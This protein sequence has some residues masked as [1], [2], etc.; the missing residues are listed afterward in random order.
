MFEITCKNRIPGGEDVVFDAEEIE[1]KNGN[2][3]GT[4]REYTQLAK[5]ADGWNSQIATE[6]IY[7]VPLSFVLKIEKC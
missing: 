6:H 3:V 1:M 4:T 5:V 2:L 7:T